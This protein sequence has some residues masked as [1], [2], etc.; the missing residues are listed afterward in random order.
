MAETI[1]EITVN[2]KDEFGKLVVKEISKE[3]LSKG[4]WCTII[5]LYQELDPKSKKYGEPKATIRRY[6]KS[7][8]QFRQQ[9]KFNISSKKQAIQISEILTKWFS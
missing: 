5:F 1:D 7:G 2:Y 8:G 3:I 9:S 6:R 4:S